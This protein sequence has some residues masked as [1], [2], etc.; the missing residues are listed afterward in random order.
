MI[1]HLRMGFSTTIVLALSILTCLMFTED[2]LWAQSGGFALDFDGQGGHIEIANHTD[3][4]GGSGKSFTIEAWVKIDDFS[5]DRPI[6][7]KWKD[8]QDKEW[9]MV[10]DSGS[11]HKVSVAIEKNGNN[12]EFNA[13]GGVLQPNVWHHV[14]MSYNGGSKLLRIVVDGVDEGSTTVPDGMPSTNSSVQIG[15]HRYQSDKLFSGQIDEVRIWN[16]ARTASEIQN[17][18]QTLL[19]GNEP[20]LIA[21][22]RFDEGTETQTGDLTGRGHTGQFQPGPTNGPQSTAS[23][24]PIFGGSFITVTSPNGGEVLEQ[25]T[26]HTITWTSGGLPGDVMIEY[27]DNGGTNWTIS[28]NS[29]NNDGS[30][31]WTVP[32]VV[33]SNVLVRVS[34]ETNTAVNDVSNA[35]FSIVEPP[36]NNPLSFTDITLAAGTGGP[37]G[38]GQTGGHAAAFA[39]V[40][41]DMRPDLYH[42]MLF[43]TQMRDLF[44]LNK[45]GN[46][47]ANEGVARGIDD[48]DG[49]SHGAIFADLDNDGDFDLYNGTT[50]LD[51]APE[52]NNIYENDGSG[53]FTDITATI[54]TQVRAEPTRG[55]VAFDMDKDG[56][57]DL[58]AITNFQ[59]S[60]DPPGE[61]NEIYRNDGGMQFTEITSGALY[62]APAGQGATDTDYDGD[63]DIDIIAGNRTGDLN[64]LRNNGQGDFTLITPSAI[65]INHRGREGATLGDI[66]NDGHLDLLLSDFDDQQ[67]FALEH[68]YI[69]D[70]DATFTFSRTFTETGGFMGA[71]GDLDNDGDL[72]IIFAGDETSYLNDGAGNFSPGPTVPVNGIDDPRAVA[73]ADIDDD[74]DLDFA[75]GAKRSR[76][77][78]VR[79]NL[80]SGN[81]LKIDLVSPAGQAGAFG[82]KVRIYAAGDLG[83]QLL[84]FREARCVNGYLGQGD[85][86][87]HF[88]LGSQTG[89]DLEVIFL[90]GT[91]V[92]ATNVSSRQKIVIDGRGNAPEISSLAPLSGP[93]GSDVSIAGTDFSNVTEVRFDV[94]AAAS[95]AIIS[96]NLIEVTVP[97]GAAT[98]PVTVTNAVGSDVSAQV[99][100]VTTGNTVAFLPI[101]D[102]QVKLTE[103]DSNYEN[104]STMKVE[105]GKFVSYLKFDVSGLAG[106]VANATLRLRVSDGSSDGGP[107]GGSVFLVDNNFLNSGTPWEE[108]TVTSGNAPPISGSP[109]SA[110]GSV[111]TDTDADFDVTGA[112]SGN[113]IYSFA[114]Q[115]GSGNQVKYYT[116]EGAISPQLLIEPAA[117]GGNDA[118]VAANDIATTVEDIP[119]QIDVAANDSDPDGVLDLSSVTIVSQAT[120]GAASF[121]GNGIVTYTPNSGYNG[122][123][124]FSYTIKDNDGATS[125]IATVGVTINASSGG[126][127][128]TLTFTPTDDNQVKLTEPDSNYENKSTMKVEAGKFVSYLKFDVSGLAGGVANATLRLRVSDGSS[129]GGPDGGSVFLVDNNFLNSGTPW[130]EETVTSGNAPPISGSPLS[131]AGSVSTDTDA[132]F[133][134]TGAVS[135]NGIYSFAIQSGSGNQVKYYTKEGAISPQLLIEPAAAGGND[136]PVAANDIATT[137]ED[138]PVQIDVAANDSD[139]DGVLDLSS[140]TIVSQATNGAASFTGNGIVTYTPNSGYNGADQF[141]YTIKDNDGATSNIATVG[142]TI[143]ASGGSNDP[144]VAVNDSAATDQEVAVQ[145]DVAANDSDSDG[146]LDL[147]SVAIVSGPANGAANPAGGGIV[148]YSPNSGFSGNDSFSYTIEDNE[149]ALSNIATVSVVVNASGGGGSQ[150]FTFT[151]TD[152]G[153][154]KLTDATQNY[155]TKSTAKVESGKFSSYFKF[156]VS[157]VSGS[158]QSA[159]L[160]LRVGDSSSDAGDTGGSIFLVSNDFATGGGAWNE[161]QLTAGNAPNAT[162]SPLSTVGPVAL[163]ETVDFDVTGA[164]TGNGIF[165]FALTSSSP[166]QVKY[167]SKEGAFVP[168]L[169]IETSSGGG[170]VVPIAVDDNASTP[171]GISV[172]VN[173]LNNDSDP[174]GSLAPSTVAIVAEPTDG[175]AVINPNSG[176]VTY[177]PESGFSGT[178]SFEYTVEDNLGGVSNSATVTVS[179]TGNNSSPIASDDNASTDEDV[180]VIID[181]V[182]N[183]SDSDG[184]IDPGTVSVATG[185]SN[186]AVSVDPTSGEVT[187]I[188]APDFFG[189]DSFGYTVRDNEGAV[190]NEATVFIA[191]QAV[192]DPPIAVNDAAIIEGSSEVINVTANDIDPE[193]ALDVTTVTITS[194]PSQGSVVVNPFSGIITYTAGSGFSGSDAFSYKVE[195]DG[196]LVSNAA[197][198]TVS[199]PGS[200]TTVFTFQASDDVYTKSTDPISNFGSGNTLKVE[201]PKF[202][203]YLKFHISGLNGAVQ[204]ATLKLFVA[205]PSENGGSIYLISNNLEGTSTPWVESTL[206]AGN[207]PQI[208]TAALDNFGQADENDTLTVDLTAAITGDGTYSFAI[209]SS[210]TDQVKYAANES[211]NPAPILEIITDGVP[212]SS[213]TITSFS[214][215]SG[216]EGTEVTIIGN[217]FVSSS[218]GSP[219]SGTIRIMPLGNS[220]TRGVAG[221]TDNAG[222]RN[223]LAELLDTEGVSFDFVGTIDNGTGFDNDHEGHG[224]WRADQIL[225]E[226][227]TFLNANPP[228]IVL[229]HI[230]TNDVSSDQST[231]STIAEIGSLLDGIETFDSDIF[232]LLASIIPRRDSKDNATSDLND[233][234]ESLAV[235][236]QAAGKN[237][238]YASINEAFRANSNWETDYFPAGD[239]VHPNDTGYAVMAGVWFD[240]VQNILAG[241]AGITVAFNNT[242]ALNLSV[243]SVNQLRAVVPFGATT[244][245]I[246]VTTQ[247]GSGQSAGDFTVLG[248][249]TAAL[250]FRNPNGVSAWESGSTHTMTWK[251]LGRVEYVKI[252]SSNDAGSTWQVVAER[253]ENAGRFVWSAPEIVESQL[254]FRISDANNPSVR[255][256]SASRVAV[257]SRSARSVLPNLNDIRGG[258]EV[259]RSA[260]VGATVRSDMNA[261]GKT[262]LIDF[263][264]RWDLGDSDLLRLKRSAPDLEV[265]QKGELALF[266]PALEAPQGSNLEIPVFVEGEQ[267]IRGFQFRVTFDPDQLSYMA[268]AYYRNERDM[269]IESFPGE[270]FVDIIGYL[271]E[272]GGAIAIDGEAVVLTGEIAA[273]F[274]NNPDIQVSDVLFVSANR[275]PFK[276]LSVTNDAAGG[277]LPTQFQLF[278]NYPNPFNPSTQINFNLPQK[279]KVKIQIY[280]IRGELVATL[281]NKEAAPGRHKVVWDGRD[282]HGVQVASGVYIYRI[283]AG[284][285]KDSRRMTLLK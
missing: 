79:N 280:N 52:I 158:V 190:S 219:L 108:E 177:T 40:D 281:L 78:L 104:K 133:D 193:G 50:G 15:R 196:G 202:I 185:P 223:D 247:F 171:E 227:N 29:T 214:P 5:Q 112:V 249:S 192:N 184:S 186:G 129:D 246:G 265:S 42:T 174:D 149:G 240:L 38:A 232:V 242:E 146:A 12:F 275:L 195:D 221:S 182:G 271:E 207:A 172:V 233:E 124:Q 245:K 168:E 77:W 252:E 28:D 41:G 25:G 235:A 213:P 222:Y 94:T 269:V 189:D 26:S 19:D 105:A 110:A 241:S 90:D 131:A 39:D 62:G 136:A 217:D 141:S 53:F 266:I 37:T 93:V 34:D 130:E 267:P 206:T 100:T 75:I 268:P 117:A 123:D 45:G 47:F 54:G 21:Y 225:A 102:N 165:S 8:K 274:K 95:F 71:F 262:D 138:I 31:S 139:P 216:L 137:V 103:P 36:P 126:G 163:N 277:L 226:L 260:G 237:V 72:D 160:R 257:Q 68:L 44:F 258:L 81:W 109:L 24:A 261:D 151:P 187:Y 209:Q 2:S 97:A 43:S 85:R 88:G 86:T 145:I 115:S 278:Q 143:N 135:G 229:L 270:G 173:V 18:M 76:N 147:A 67:G 259:G 183:D 272:E 7:Q 210:S 154:V 69:N 169:I 156:S 65:G 35:P 48:F 282:T 197:T 199:E 99:F 101:D 230:G 167:Y 194:F 276:D 92:T 30:F 57:L 218:S 107:D 11:S 80:N 66:N 58:L 283:S 179:V 208:T 198:V 250:E 175:T 51:G 162:G 64:I 285:F 153:Q 127:S 264:N 152:D 32:F 211:S 231:A 55:V 27:S 134:V 228:D 159:R 256:I 248:G 33:S 59:G 176:I 224:G 84:A 161:E 188:G 128:Q 142:V 180:P 10:I 46:T 113:G 140:V 253:V 164:V 205:S 284:G 191:V 155:G 201:S 70:G 114:I 96:D 157:G 83:G 236:R 150:T 74:G 251:T 73:L 91:N 204:S 118:P 148:T 121:T 144:P 16:I 279:S 243:D 4:Q 9:G 89:V 200:Q 14:A 98:G 56:D 120:N 82:A 20:G 61:R 132:D 181:V 212:P 244:G 238:R 3:F 203:S 1:S 49:G 119:V 178:D 63:G 215:Q 17:T 87:I 13:A 234:I 255:S 22:Y 166:D 170:N 106:G 263:L 239:L 254:Q 23:T 60:D 273:G 122:A 111:S 125:N 116:K 6:I 220:I